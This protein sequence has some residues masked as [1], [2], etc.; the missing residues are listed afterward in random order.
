MM[1]D[2]LKIGSLYKFYPEGWEIN[3]ECQKHKIYI[4]EL[5]EVVYRNYS[6]IKILDLHT[7]E[8]IVILEESLQENIA[9]NLSFYYKILTTTGIIGWVEVYSELI[10]DWVLVSL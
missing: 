3:R 7:N 4:G 9:G 6:L 8:M 1:G 5:N 2:N 10:S